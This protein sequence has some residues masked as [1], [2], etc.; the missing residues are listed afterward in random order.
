MN[1]LSNRFEVQ[2]DV[3]THI[4]QVQQTTT[5]LASGL[6]TWVPRIT[7]AEQLYQI[8]ATAGS[9]KTQLALA[10]LAQ[11]AAQGLRPSMSALT[12]RWPTTWPG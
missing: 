5:L 8:E 11:A 10:L 3:A 1:F 6:A 9:G 7:H 4:G 2:P 12:A